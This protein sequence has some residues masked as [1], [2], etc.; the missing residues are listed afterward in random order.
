MIKIRVANKLGYELCE[1][2]GV[3][4]LSYPSSRTRRGRVKENGRISPT[5]C[6]EGEIFRMDHNETEYR[7]RKLTPRECLRLMS[8]DD[9]D[10]DKILAVNSNTQAYKQAGNSIVVD[11]MCRMFEKLIG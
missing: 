7:I 2:G 11:V 6:A 3:A 5:V 10:I 1:I 9:S 8:V 4:D